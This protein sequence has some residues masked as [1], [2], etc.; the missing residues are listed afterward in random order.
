VIQ[1]DKFCDERVQSR[2][3]WFCVDFAW[4]STLFQLRARLNKKRVPLRDRGS[5]PTRVED[6][7]VLNAKFEHGRGTLPSVT[8]YELNCP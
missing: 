6:T 8:F 3:L 5:L 2:N 1:C 7:D 4:K